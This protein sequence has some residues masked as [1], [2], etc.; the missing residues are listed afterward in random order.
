MLAAFRTLWGCARSFNIADGGRHQY[1]SADATTPPALMPPAIRTFPFE[2]S[3]AVWKARAVA[4]L[5]AGV[6]VP[7]AGSYSSLVAVTATQQPRS[8]LS[9]RPFHS[10]AASRCGKHVRLRGCQWAST[11]RRLDRTARWSRSRSP[12]MPARRSPE[13][14][15][16]AAASRCGSHVRSRGRQWASTYRRLDRTAR[17]SRSRSPGMPARRSPE[18]LRSAAASRCGSHV[19][20]RGRQWASTCRRLDRTAR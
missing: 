14:L 10:R 13:P 17:W 15:R 9:P 18:P 11:Y 20:S 12:G 3:V 8:R 16:S 6:H 2:S 19:R 7:A 1:N 4:R 5:L